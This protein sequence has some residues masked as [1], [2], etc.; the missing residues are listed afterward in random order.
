M[1]KRNYRYFY[2]FILSLSFL[3][4]FI[5]ACV[6]THL[7]LRKSSCQQQQ[8]TLLEVTSSSGPWGSTRLL[9]GFKPGFPAQVSQINGGSRCREAQT[10]SSPLCRE[11]LRAGDRVIPPPRANAF[12]AVPNGW[13]LSVSS[14]SPAEEVTSLSALNLLDLHLLAVISAQL[15]PAGVFGQPDRSLWPAGGG[16]GVKHCLEV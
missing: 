15:Q 4:A 13:A 14:L 7:T 10:H 2:A 6:I 8:H 3:T 1:G 11:T 12:G 16:W 5:F 9:C